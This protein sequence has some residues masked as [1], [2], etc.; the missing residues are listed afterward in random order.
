MCVCK[1]YEHT[2]TFYMAFQTAFQ[3]FQNC[4][5]QI[6]PNKA[7]FKSCLIYYLDHVW[8]PVRRP[9][10]PH[11]LS[12]LLALTNKS[13]FVDSKE[14]R[15][16]CRINHSERRRTSFFFSLSLSRVLS[17][18]FQES[19]VDFWFQKSRITVVFH[20]TIY[21][22]LCP[23]EA[24]WTRLRDVFTDFFSRHT[25]NV[26]LFRKQHLLFHS[27]V[28]FGEYIIMHFQKVNYVLE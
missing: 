17:L 11:L 10:A 1:L 25:V 12:L 9:T 14:S 22:S 18:L 4:A 5:I 2:I 19:L 8:L 13:S 27:C 3:N 15:L 21:Q 16:K 6:N 23:V 24:I 26:Y 20:Q 28:L 7:D